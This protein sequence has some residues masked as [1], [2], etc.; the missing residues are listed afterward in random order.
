MDFCSESA[1]CFCCRFI[2]CCFLLHPEHTPFLF[3][4]SLAVQCIR[5]YL[6]YPIVCMKVFLLNV[7]T[8]M[9]TFIFIIV[10]NSP[11]FRHSPLFKMHE[12]FILLE[13]LHVEEILV[14][15]ICRFRR[16]TCSQV[17]VYITNNFLCCKLNCWILGLLWWLDHSTAFLCLFG[18]PG[19]LLLHSVLTMFGNYHIQWVMV[20]QFCV[21]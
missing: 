6:W 11:S 5:P 19:G 1:L 7:T 20:C 12:I 8:L 18:D 21:C 3:T 15:S 4:P 10:I 2:S 14:P 16:V 9:C 17:F 13:D